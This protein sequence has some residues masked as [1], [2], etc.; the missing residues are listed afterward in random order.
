MSIF[1]FAAKDDMLIL[2]GC[3]IFVDKSSTLVEAK[4][5][6]VFRDFSNSGRYC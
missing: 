1:D 6:M 4:H 5:L 3:T 2:A